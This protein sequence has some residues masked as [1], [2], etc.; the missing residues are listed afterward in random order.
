MSEELFGGWLQYYETLLEPLGPRRRTAFA[1]LC[2]ERALPEKFDKLKI[3]G[4]DA[5]M[6]REA[7]DYAWEFAGGTLKTKIRP[8]RTQESLVASCRQA[9]GKAP[10]DIQQSAFAVLAALA[11][12]EN[13]VRAA[14]A[15][16]HAL[17]AVC[18]RLGVRIGDH[19]EPE[20]ALTVP[21]IDRENR[22]HMAV[23]EALKATD[24]L[25]AG[26]DTLRSWLK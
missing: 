18:A 7:L 12:R 5:A 26:R 4:F 6:F 2:A 8:K 21:E 20:M 15:A 14:S 3:A 10:H 13:T 11:A 25:H 22:V 16:A 23:L 19:F 17:D 24:E 1:C 9:I